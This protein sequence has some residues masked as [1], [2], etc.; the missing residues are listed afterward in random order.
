MRKRHGHPALLGLF[1]VS[2]LMVLFVGV[3]VTAGG[4][5]FGG[6]ERVVMYFNGSIYGL[7]VGAPVVFRGVRLGSV[8][9]I[10]VAYDRSHNEVT[11][12]VLAELDSDMLGSLS[13]EQRAGMLGA[14]MS[15]L[16]ERG[17]R[18]QLAMQSLLTGQ[19]YIDLDFRPGKATEANKPLRAEI[20]IPTVSTPLQDL[21][22]QVDGLDI[23]RLV[24][25]LSAIASSGRRL[26]EGPELSHAVKDIEAVATSLRRLTEQLDRRAGPLADAS[27]STLEATRLAM[28][29][30]GNTAV[31]VNESAQRV[32]QTFN[33]EG[34]M[35]QDLRKASQELSRAAAV[36][37]D[38]AKDESPLNQNLQKA[39]K[40]V[41][42]AA[43][44]LRELAD[45]LDQQPESVLKGRR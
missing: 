18:A 22:N 14:S 24:G 30:M 17:L 8:S 38:A 35:V 31:T 3:F 21:K 2:A 29:R 32:G 13:G 27:L 5:L 10:G 36:L 23:K 42:Q 43:R 44:A 6:K 15:G 4:K 28:E 37:A 19:L 1:V 26:L 12:P 40:D 11:I 41:S 34:P 39:L 20:E 25:D 33:P 9:S 16:V 7:Q 45:T